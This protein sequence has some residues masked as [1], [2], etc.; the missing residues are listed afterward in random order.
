M[1]NGRKLS[2]IMANIVDDGLLDEP[3]PE[4]P[5]RARVQL[6]L[7]ESVHAAEP[8][9]EMTPERVAEVLEQAEAATLVSE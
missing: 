5:Q 2:A 3:P 6:P 8:D 4:A 9:R 7:V 1:T